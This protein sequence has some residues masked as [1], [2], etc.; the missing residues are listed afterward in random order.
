[1]HPIIFHIPFLN[2]PIYGYGIMMVCAFLGTQWLSA[3]L[4][5]GK[6]IDPEIFVNATLLALVS[7]V[8]G[9]RL[10][11]VLENLSQYTRSDLSVWQNLFNMIN[12]RSGGLT[13]YGGVILACPIAI[14]YFIHKKVP[15][16]P[17]LDICAP[18]VMLGLGIG[19]IGCFLSGCCYGATAEVPWAIRF[20]YG[21]DAY[22]EQFYNQISN[23]PTE[24]LNHTVPAPL[25]VPTANGVR[26]LS[27]QEIG[28]DPTLLALAGSEK[29]NP[30][31]PTQ[32]YSTFN[33]LL[34]MGILLI[35]FSLPHAPGRVF[36][37]ML[38][39]EG[40]TRFMLEMLRV[41]PPVLGPMSLSMVLGMVLLVAGAILWFAFGFME[42][43]RSAKLVS[44]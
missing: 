9:S 16:R 26:L 11:S 23:T 13:F 18:C 28:N 42:S 38:M 2:I 14:G 27:R 4:A 35:Y 31:H 19:R 22:V 44:T 15:I 32:F 37:M 24:K 5:K 21:S 40:P 8:I 25:V 17:A 12:I 33:S 10:S 7:G 20:P 39:L 29:S 30:V 6:G 43:G 34:I 41:E 3:R 36:A 1:M